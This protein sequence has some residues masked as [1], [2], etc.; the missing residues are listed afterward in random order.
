M[1]PKIFVAQRIP[2][3]ALDMLR[4]AGDVDVNPD[5]DRVLP[6]DELIQAVRT[7]DYLLSL[8]TNKIDAGVMDANPNLKVIANFAVG[9]DNIDVPAATARKIPVTNTPGVLTETTADFAWT[10][11]MAVARR[12]VEGDRFTRAG[13]FNAWGPMLLLGGDVYGK[14][15]GVVGFGR[16]GR[17]VARRA[18]GFDMRVLYA[19]AI[20]ADPATERDLRATRVDLETLLREADFVS[21]HTPLLPE[22]RHLINPRTLGMMKRTAYLINTSRGPVVDEKALADALKAGTIAGA[23]LDVY[24]REPT[25]EPALLALENVVL[26]PHI[27]SASLETRTKMA[28]MAAA[29]LIAVLKGE[30]PANLVNPEI[31]D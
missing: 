11:L 21:L 16:I 7:H 25:C 5:P 18:L 13:R 23:G 15:L 2:E 4:A 1:I 24:E 22:T 14:T 28:C 10:L 9:F 19:D 31:S 30:R 3:P 17:S 29:N 8:L 6:H 26:A 12:V 27:A 20:P